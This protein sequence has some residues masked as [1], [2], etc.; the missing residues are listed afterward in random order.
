M[1]DVNRVVIIGR[2]TRDAELKYTQAGFAISNFSIAV[3]RRRKNGEQWVEEA[4]YFDINLFGKQAESLKPY[5]VKGK[6]IAVEGELKQDR[7]EQD[8]QPRSKV[9]ISASNVQLLGGGQGAG[10]Q[11]NAAAG[12]S[13]APQY[14]GHPSGGYSPQGGNYQGGAKPSGGFV[15]QGGSLPQQP[16]YQGYEN[17]EFEDDIPF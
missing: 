4:N 1:A 13:Y 17:E 10:G 9:V 5:L 15:P 11:G 14:G 3:N 12:G 16:K 7:W 6:Q 8:G 2:L